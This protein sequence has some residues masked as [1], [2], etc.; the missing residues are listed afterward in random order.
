MEQ[1]T[2][3][4]KNCSNQFTI[5]PDDFDFYTKIAVPPPTLC[6]QCRSQRRMTWRND[7]HFYPWQCGLCGGKTLSIYSEDKPMPVYCT[8][9]WW[10]D[11]WDAK[12]WG[13]EY[14]PSKSF[15]A[16]FRELLNSV[17]SLA[18]LNDDGITSKNCQYTNY[19]ARG[20]DCYLVINSW[21]VEN[22]MYS[23]CLVGAKDIMDSTVL[24]ANC[25]N[26]YSAVYVDNCSNCRNIYNSS[27]LSDCAYCFDCRGC[28][29]CFMCVGLR[30]KSYYFKNE[31][32]SKDEYQRIVAE[33]RLE[34]RSG[35]AKAE[36]EFRALA[37]SFPHRYAN[38]RNC[39]NCTG[40]YL[41]NS[42]NA[43]NCF[44][45]VRVEDSKFFESGDTIKDSYDCLSGGEQ[46][47]CYECINPDNSSRT[48]FT[49]YCHRGT[50]VFYSDSCQSCENV[51]G[52]VGL[53]KA[54]YCIL[55]KQYSKEE[56]FKLR[57]RMI[58]QMKEAGEYG[59]FFPSHLSSFGYNESVAQDET[60][61]SPED[62]S[63]RGFRWQ[64][65]IPVTK[66]RETLPIIPD[67]ISDVPDTILDEILACQR[68]GRNYK[69]LEQEL[70]FYR[71]NTIP[72]PGYCFFCRLGDL[73]HRRGS[74]KLWHR[75]C[76]CVGVASANSIYKNIAAHFHGTGKCSNTFET[77]YAP[78]RSEIIY[79]E[80]CYNS[81]VV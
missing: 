61:L 40:Q 11:G 57:S 81:E 26:I 48:A 62:A 19:F 9:C 74:V 2:R 76:Q 34:T 45:A 51:F 5:E 53:K 43:K 67:N 50:D 22:C 10:S 69:I 28:T 66:G 16:Q 75:A 42:K 30:N 18:I 58:E 55:N 37:Q 17:P 15:F 24:L 64:D 63:A 7:Y 46:E 27:G 35:C 52:C 73:Y 59:E 44:I 13:R 77:S 80:Q 56:Y 71:S 70:S 23:S 1:E 60:P 29:N 20:K 33:Y 78:D 72:V 31:Q 3:R 39:V 4:C 21:K 6:P 12:Q 32:Y 25:R 38:L 36:E 41:T 54:K 68:C 8:K 14:D 65:K 79:C 47:L 49:T